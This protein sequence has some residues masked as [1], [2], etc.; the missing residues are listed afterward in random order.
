MQQL[1]NILT[2]DMSELIAMMKESRRAEEHV[3]MVM[4][5]KHRAAPSEF[6]NRQQRRAAV[7]A[8]R[9]REHA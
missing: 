6:G 7:A 1:Q 2:K 4:D 5:R 8:S 9:K 3:S